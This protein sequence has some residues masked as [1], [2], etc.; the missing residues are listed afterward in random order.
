[1]KLA[2]KNN[3]V[4]ELIGELGTAGMAYL[5][6]FQAVDL[7]LHRPQGIDLVARHK[8]LGTFAIFEAKGNTAG[9]SK[10]AKYGDEMT[11]RW[12]THWLRDT[13]ARSGGKGDFD[14]LDDAMKDRDLMLAAVV[15]ARFDANLSKKQRVFLKVGVQG[16]QPP[17]DTFDPFNT[18]TSLAP[19]KWKGFS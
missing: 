19:K 18:S 14:A 4:A 16:Y 10:G 13:V 17:A 8:A 9:L 12:I 15:R 6:G 11:G 2:G 1:M 5:L 7:N 3:K